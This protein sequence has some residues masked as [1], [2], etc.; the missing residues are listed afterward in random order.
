[1]SKWAEIK[2][3]GVIGLVVVNQDLHGTPILGLDLDGQGGIFYVN[4]GD[5]KPFKLLKPCLRPAEPG[6]DNPCLLFAGK[7]GV[8]CA[9]PPE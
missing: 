3:T 6:P 4:A 5:T 8:P 9:T 2:G 1:M 7:D